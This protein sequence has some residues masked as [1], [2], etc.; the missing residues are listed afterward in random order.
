MQSFINKQLNLNNFKKAPVLCLRL[1]KSQKNYNEKLFNYIRSCGND[2]K[3][4]LLN[5]PKSN[6]FHTL[7]PLFT[8]FVI[9]IFYIL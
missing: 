5:N 3:N 4:Y 6:K 2:L 1:I 9:L 7:L 8:D